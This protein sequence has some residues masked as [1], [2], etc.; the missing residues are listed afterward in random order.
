MGYVTVVPWS[1]FWGDVLPANSYPVFSLGHV[2]VSDPEALAT[3]DTW[4]GWMDATESAFSRQPFKTAAV[5]CRFGN[6]VGIRFSGSFFS[7][8]LLKSK[9][10]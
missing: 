6:H 3:L 1:F 5:R 7:V 9:L 4:W 10:M 8:F 2:E